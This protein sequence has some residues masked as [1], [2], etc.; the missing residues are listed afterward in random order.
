MSE[1]AADNLGLTYENLTEVQRTRLD[2]L[3]LIRPEWSR[4]RSVKFVIAGNLDLLI[5]PSQTF[6]GG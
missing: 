3:D 4:E 2:A 6:F 1:A 5:D